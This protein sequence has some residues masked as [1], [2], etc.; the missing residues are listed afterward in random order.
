VGFASCF[1]SALGVAARRA[2]LEATDAEIASAVHLQPD[3]AGGFKLAVDLDV[4]LPSVQDADQAV[5]LVHAA[6]QICPYS[7]ATRGNIEV[8]LTA[9][10]QLVA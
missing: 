1:E 8:A 10:G 6:H 3:G 7:S 4:T 5:A 9:N 2:K